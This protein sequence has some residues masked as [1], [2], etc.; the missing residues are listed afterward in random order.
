M[1]KM[2]PQMIRAL[3][4][5]ADRYEDDP[6]F[7]IRH[8]EWFVFNWVL[9]VRLYDTDI[10][11]CEEFDQL[12]EA[13][14]DA[15]NGG[16]KIQDIIYHLTRRPWTDILLGTG[17]YMEA[18]LDRMRRDELAVF[19]D[20]GWNALAFATDGG[21]RYYAKE[22]YVDLMMDLIGEDVSFSVFK[23]LNASS[24]SGYRPLVFFDGRGDLRG[25][26]CA[27]GEDNLFNPIDRAEEARRLLLHESPDLFGHELR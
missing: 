13:A 10:V 27:I 6:F 11:N 17:V 1:F 5:A 7:A 8:D 4:R 3:S 25:I 20:M 9:G 19:Q 21:Q 23:P 24:P 26:Y 2:T 22:D 15:A 18:D 14:D 16:E 12:R